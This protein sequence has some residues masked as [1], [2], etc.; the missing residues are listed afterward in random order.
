MKF[1]YVAVEGPIGVGKTAVVERLAQKLEAHTVL[2]E[3]GQNPFLKS[4]YDGG[5]GA[6]FQVELFFLLSR[7]RQQQELVQR[8]LF[9]AATICDYA[10]EKSKLFAYLNLEDSELIIYDK[11]YALLAEGVPRPDLVIYLQAP[12]EVLVRRIR[13]RGRPEET[14]LSEEYLAEVNRAYNHYF[15]HYAQTPLLVVNTAEVDF[16]KRA[17]DV[18]DLLRQVR[19]MGKGTQYYVPMANKG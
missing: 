12:T 2:E 7:Y 17:E 5:A 18:D 10:F 4:F 3:W 14:R 8:R 11:L 9:A 1:Q 13:Q 6:A 16:V 19:Q 15:F